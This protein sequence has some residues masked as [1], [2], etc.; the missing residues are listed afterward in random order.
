[1]RVRGNAADPI[2]Q[3]FICVKGQQ[4][5]EARDHPERLLSSMKREADGAHRPIAS[6]VA[7]DEIAEKLQAIREKYGSR[8]IAT[9]A[10][11]FSVANPA[12]G[13]MATAWMKALRSRMA[14][15]SNTI[16]QPG[17]AVAQ[18]LHGM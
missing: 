4:L 17:K 15:N 7:F 11:T 13:A 6:Q 18:A 10:G 1:M 16:D 5:L 12:T 14:F 2:Y 3:G 8:A 9:Y